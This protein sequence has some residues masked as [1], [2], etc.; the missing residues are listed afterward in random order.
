MLGVVIAVTAV[1]WTSAARTRKSS[2]PR[3][4]ET[5]PTIGK[6]IRQD[7]RFDELIAPDAQLE[8]LAS[9]FDWV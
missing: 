1:A 9:G 2:P 5:F 3:P 4:A 8:V 7:P 6:I